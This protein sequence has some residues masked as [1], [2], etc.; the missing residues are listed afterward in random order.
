MGKSRK[1]GVCTICEHRGY[2]EWHHIISR[3]HAIRSGQED[4]IENPNNMVELCKW[5]HDQ[6]TASMVRRIGANAK[7]TSI[8]GMWSSNGKVAFSGRA[9]QDI[10]IP[11]GTKILAFKREPEPGSRQPDLGLVYVTY[12]EE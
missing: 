2:T 6:T 3:H 11:S 4:L 8:T 10:H 9:R 12:D 5:C 7:F 1:K